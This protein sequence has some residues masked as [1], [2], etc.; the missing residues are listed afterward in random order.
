MKTVQ[1]I[2]SRSTHY[3]EKRQVQG[4]RRSSEEILAYVLGCKRLDLYLRSLMPLQ[5]EELQKVRELLKKRGEGRPLAY[6]F[7]YV[8]FY[9]YRLKITPDVLIPRQET[10]IL[11]DLVVKEIRQ[12]DFKQKVL[13][14]IGAGSGCIGLSIKKAL[15]ELQVVLSDISKKALEIARENAASHELDVTFVE[16]DLYLGKGDYVVCNPPYV[17]QGEYENLDREVR[18]FE[19]KEALLGGM[20]FYE[21]LQREIPL[22]LAPG[23]KVFFEIGKDQGGEILKLFSKPIWHKQRVIKDWAGHDRFFFLE[24]RGFSNVN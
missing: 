23:G 3:L 7:G 18:D 10:E 14:D 15:P 2:L 20:G 6:I 16:G 17:T 19:P 4:A 9:G 8:D 11:V 22:H 13:W 1:E 21:R 24:F 12:E 5:E